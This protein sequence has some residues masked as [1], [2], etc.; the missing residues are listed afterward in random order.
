MRIGRPEGDNVDSPRGPGGQRY[1]TMTVPCII[2]P[3]TRQKYGY[4]P[5]VGNVCSYD[6]SCP[7]PESQSPSG[8]QPEGQLP[9]VVEWEPS[10]QYHWI[11]LPAG[12]VL[13][14]VMLTE[15]RKAFA[16]WPPSPRP[17]YTTRGAAGVGVGPPGV[18]V[19]PP[20]VGVAV[21]G[22]VMVFSHPTQTP[23]AIVKAKAS[24]ARPSFGVNAM[25]RT[26]TPARA[27]LIP[28]FTDGAS[29]P[30][31]PDTYNPGPP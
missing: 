20:G 15:S 16:L 29:C 8:T 26:L 19:G 30:S 18:G 4:V 13:V 24:T 31:P 2:A 25:P 3:W 21:P 9:E 22:P 11:V 7:I 17:T 27:T 14:G 28:V 1:W 12:I 5:A 23:T 6:V 10:T